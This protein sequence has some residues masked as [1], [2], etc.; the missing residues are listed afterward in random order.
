[1]LTQHN[2]RTH[3]RTSLQ[4]FGK[5]WHAVVGRNFGSFV[6]HESRSFIYFYIGKVAV[7]LFKA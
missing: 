5:T 3:T 7:L 6:V 1:M 4:R 2:A